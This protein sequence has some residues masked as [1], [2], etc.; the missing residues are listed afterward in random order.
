M[1]YGLTLGL[2]GFP[3]ACQ[4]LGIGLTPQYT[5]LAGGWPY[6]FLKDV[7]EAG[8][9]FYLMLDTEEDARAYS[10]IPVDGIITDHIEIVEKYYDDQS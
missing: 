7:E 2:A 3:E 1:P 9:R 6:R 8:A 5:R 4:G 10:D